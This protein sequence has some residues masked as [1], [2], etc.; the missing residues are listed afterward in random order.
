[1]VTL[2]S[3]NATQLRPGSGERPREPRELGLASDDP[4][5]IR[6]EDLTIDLD[7][8]TVCRR[9][10]GTTTLQEKPFLLLLSLLRHP[11]RLVTRE[12][13]IDGLWP[14]GLHVEFDHGLNTAVKKLRQ[15][16]D[17][18]ARAPRFIE[19][20]PKRGYRLLSQARPVAADG[21]SRPASGRPAPEEPAAQAIRK[22][23]PLSRWAVAATLAALGSLAALHAPSTEPAVD[24]PGTPD[25]PSPAALAEPGI[26][27]AVMP[28]RNLDASPEGDY[29]VEG[30][31]EEIVTA[32]GALAPESVRLIASS[33]TVRFRDAGLPADAVGRALGADYLVTGSLRRD[34]G[35]SRV[36]L[37]VVHAE[38]REQRWSTSYELEGE[39]VLAM[40]SRIARGL[41]RALPDVLSA[42]TL[43]RTAT[44]ECRDVE[45][46]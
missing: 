21:N 45:A 25:S 35:R 28:L 39:D 19:T 31:T 41:V 30:L 29:F 15:A 8:R 10:G 14:P 1:L 22:S 33:S 32:L 37:Q 5:R 13:L 40:Q 36:S 11:G 2:Q 38:T 24:T 4:G 23:R 18:S 12:E 34:A 16:L 17:D 9:D 42:P 20:V 46:G 3:V 26:S 44:V 43:R 27:L 6:I 7:N